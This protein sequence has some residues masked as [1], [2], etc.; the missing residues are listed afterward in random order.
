MLIGYGGMLIT[1]D[2]KKRNSSMFQRAY[3]GL[4][5]FVLLGVG[6][7]IGSLVWSVSSSQKQAIEALQQTVDSM[8]RQVEKINQLEAQ[9]QQAEVEKNRAIASSVEHNK[10]VESVITQQKEKDLS[11][12]TI[13]GENSC[14]Y[15]PIPDSV[16]RVLKHEEDRVGSYSNRAP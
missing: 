5:L 11:N 13:N 7:G 16:Y 14:Y 1:T 2:V 6:V 8:H 9:R 3:M 15:S 4:I 12:D 10:K